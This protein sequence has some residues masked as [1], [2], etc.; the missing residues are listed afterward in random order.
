MLLNIWQLRRRRKSTGV[1]E[2]A[3]LA[4]N[5]CNSVL[6]TAKREEAEVRNIAC[7]RTLAQW[8]L[9]PY[10]RR[11]EVLRIRMAIG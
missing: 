3:V 2:G 11:Y 6:E 9:F 10:T 5:G 4:V 1:W 8:V 7:A